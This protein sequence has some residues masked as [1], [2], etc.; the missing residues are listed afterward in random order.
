MQANAAASVAPVRSTLAE[1]QLADGEVSRAHASYA[2][3]VREYNHALSLCPTFVDIRTKLANTLRDMGDH[4]TAI[5]EYRDAV[6]TNPDYVPARLQLGVTLY[7]AGDK[8]KAIDEWHAVLKRDPDNR[9]AKMYL[10]MVG[11]SDV[12]PAVSG[13]A[14]AGDDGAGDDAAVEGDGE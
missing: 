5:S 8:Q 7:S 6:A 11:E 10:R 3:A 14:G 2:E 13:D 4:S 12:Y 1:A 9:N